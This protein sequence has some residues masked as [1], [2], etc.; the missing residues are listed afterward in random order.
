MR[1]T[2][3]GDADTFFVS[4]DPFLS[5]HEAEHKLVLGLIGRLRVDSGIYG[6]EPTCAGADWDQGIF[7][8]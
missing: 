1:A 8:L 6:L 4:V 5:A 3:V 2:R 7:E